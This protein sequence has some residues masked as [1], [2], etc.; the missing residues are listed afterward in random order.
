MALPVLVAPVRAE[1]R[2]LVD[3]GVLDNLPIDV[4][5]AR[6]EGPIIAVDAMRSRFRRAN[7]GA[8][9]HPRRPSLLE[10]LPRVAGLSSRRAARDH[11]EL[12]QVVIEPELPDAGML[13]FRR[14][15]Q[16]VEAGRAAAERALE[17]GALAALMKSGPP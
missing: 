15:P 16:M 5:A 10:I 17:S 9:D 13:E 2:L 7:A 6:E 12:A 8:G 4:M 3:G 11:R 1:G 14:L